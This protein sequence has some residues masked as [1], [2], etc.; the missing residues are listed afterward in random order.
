MRTT[1]VAWLGILALGVVTLS[2]QSGRGAPTD[3]TL[4]DLNG[5]RLDGSRGMV[6]TAP[7][8]A[9][10]FR[11]GGAASSSPS[12]GSYESDVRLETA[13]SVSQIASHYTAQILAATWREES[14]QA[15]G[16]H[17]AAVRFSGTT[18]TGDPLTILL[19][20]TRLGGTRTDVAVRSVRHRP[21]PSSVSRGVPGPQTTPPVP[22]G[23]AG[24]AGASAG[25]A[26][27]PPGRCSLRR[28]RS[29][30]FFATA[31]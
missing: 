11:G 18:T 19:T 27:R 25:A 1:A 30:A 10:V 31:I 7:A 23:R 29:R 2:G 15:G 6:L 9:I 20:I 26:R 14:R 12:S 22:P 28:R 5:S 17:M 13:L 16:E 4:L 8:G 3:F 24:G 21:V